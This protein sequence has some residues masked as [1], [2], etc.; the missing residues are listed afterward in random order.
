MRLT[1]RTINSDKNVVLESK[2]NFK[3]SI[4][5][6]SFSIKEF[7]FKENIST[8]LPSWKHFR[9][10]HRSINQY[11]VE[12]KS[13]GFLELF[14]L[15]FGPFLMTRKIFGNFFL[16]IRKKTLALRK[17]TFLCKYRN[18]TILRG[19]KLSAPFMRYV[20]ES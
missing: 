13:F 19:Q 11:C 8:I 20:L 4:F 14:F 9:G 18:S 2:I 6:S 10:S 16:Y 5:Q 17:Q 7:F 3:Q 1:N 12:S 15:R